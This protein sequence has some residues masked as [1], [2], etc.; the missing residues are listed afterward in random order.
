MKETNKFSKIYALTA[1]ILVLVFLAFV[2][3][4]A[5]KDRQKMKKEHEILIAEGNSILKSI[6]QFAKTNGR[7]PETEE[8]IKSKTLNWQTND[9][10]YYYKNGMFKL[11]VL[12][13][14]PNKSVILYQYLSGNEHDWYL[15]RAGDVE[16]RKSIGKA[17]E[18]K[19]PVA[20]PKLK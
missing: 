4:P 9:W 13:G 8:E 10:S 11:F 6:E 20:P 17:Y 14:T 5:I 16:G 19:L 15:Q 12:P 7:L 3:T 2:I 18:L 1:G